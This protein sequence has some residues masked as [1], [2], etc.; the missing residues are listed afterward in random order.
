MSGSWH[1]VSEVTKNRVQKEYKTDEYAR[2]RRKL[3]YVVP[4][5]VKLDDVMLLLVFGGFTLE[6][7]EY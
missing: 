4:V 5:L 3:L 2:K 7:Y 6:L 1:L